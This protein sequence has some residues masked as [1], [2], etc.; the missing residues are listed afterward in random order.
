MFAFNQGTSDRFS[1]WIVKYAGGGA[2]KQLVLTYSRLGPWQ[3]LRRLYDEARRNSADRE[4]YLL[5]DY[6]LDDIGV[7][8]RFDLRTDDLVKRLRAGG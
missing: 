6:C 5:S 8:R 4:L 1:G 2:Q 7:R 3:L